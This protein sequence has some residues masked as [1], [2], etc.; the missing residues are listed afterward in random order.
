MQTC[1]SLD[2]DVIVECQFFSPEYP[3]GT[4]GYV[5]KKAMKTYPGDSTEDELFTLTVRFNNE[6]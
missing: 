1:S 2:N 4:E 3:V 5:F 6:I